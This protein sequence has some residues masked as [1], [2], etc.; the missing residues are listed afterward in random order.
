M[1]KAVTLKNSNDEEVYPVTDISL[2]NGE[3]PTAR[4]EDGAVTAAKIDFSTIGALNYSTSETATGGTWVD[5]SQIF[6][7]SY[8]ISAGPVANGQTIIT[9]SSSI[10]RVI[11]V[12]GY[13]TN[14]A[15]TLYIGASRGNSTST[16]VG[17]FY[18]DSDHH[19]VL[20]SGA[21]RSA[22]TGYVTLYYTKS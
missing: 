22:F 6:K 8:Y 19:L 16:N 17:F 11:D 2:V 1:A 14:G 20:E 21:D 18:Q 3:L 7:R 10:N 9:V 13:L 12:G 4:I 15:F 5:G